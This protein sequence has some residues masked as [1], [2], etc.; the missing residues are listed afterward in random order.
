MP[1][2]FSQEGIF[3]FIIG[4]TGDSLVTSLTLDNAQ[5]RFGIVLAYSR[6]SSKTAVRI[7]YTF[8]VP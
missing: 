2:R 5:M 4:V 6:P 3:F 8:R 7:P 1:S